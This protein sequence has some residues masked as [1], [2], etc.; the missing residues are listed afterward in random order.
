M[1]P[2]DFLE[3][4]TCEPSCGRPKRGAAVRAEGVFKALALT[5]VV[6]E[7]TSGIELTTFVN[8]K[9]GV[10]AAEANTAEFETT[11]SEVTAAAAVTSPEVLESPLH[12]SVRHCEM[13]PHFSV[14]EDSVGAKQAATCSSRRAKVKKPSKLGLTTIDEKK[15]RVGNQNEQKR[16]EVDATTPAMRRGAGARLASGRLES[17]SKTEGQASS[18]AIDRVLQNLSSLRTGRMRTPPNPAGMEDVWKVVEDVLQN[19]PNTSELTVDDLVGHSTLRRF[20][21][22]D[23]AGSCGCGDNSCEEVRCLASP[24]RFQKGLLPQGRDCPR[25]GFFAVCKHVY[26]KV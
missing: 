11:A 5:G 22:S 2:S 12:Q 1:V 20:R 16:A 6:P 26:S 23:K 3:E 8:D 18:A 25:S 24:S 7:E 19:L 4:T 13:R 14:G 10:S 15:S 21:P 9:A 17:Q